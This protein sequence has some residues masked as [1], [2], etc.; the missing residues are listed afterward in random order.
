MRTK[1]ETLEQRA[2]RE[3]RNAYAREWRAANR[4]KVKTYNQ[5]YWMRKAAQRAGNGQEAAAEGR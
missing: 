4:S 1:K 2:A 5:S 3:E